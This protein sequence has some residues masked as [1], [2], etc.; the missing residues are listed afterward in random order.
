VNADAANRRFGERVRL[1]R[2]ARDL[3]GRQLAAR[4]GLPEHAVYRIEAGARGT[5]PRVATVGEAAAL[6]TALGVD[7]SQL[8]ADEPVRVLLGGAR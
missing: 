8:V 2:R 5:S 1:V 6:A 7:L 4:A 3:T